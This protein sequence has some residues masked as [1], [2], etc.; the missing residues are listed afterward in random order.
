MPTYV[1]RRPDGTTFEQFQKISAP[2][3]T[4]DPDTGVPVTRV[5]SGGAGLQFKGDGFYLTDYVHT[6]Q[7]DR[8]TGEAAAAAEGTP[9]TESAPKAETAPKAKTAKKVATPS[10]SSTKD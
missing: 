5:I 6:G 9:K 7:K 8:K 3:L 2:A 4:E 10:T 1:Y